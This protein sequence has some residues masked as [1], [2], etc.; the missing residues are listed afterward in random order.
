MKYEFCARINQAWG[1]NV[2]REI[3]FVAAKPGPKCAPRELDNE[4]TPSVRR[5]KR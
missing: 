3:K 2:V 4:Q 1:G 5:R